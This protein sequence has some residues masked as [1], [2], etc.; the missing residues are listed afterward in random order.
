M[1]FLISEDAQVDLESILEYT[2]VKWGKG[3]MINMENYLN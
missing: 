3:Q 1:K 2:K